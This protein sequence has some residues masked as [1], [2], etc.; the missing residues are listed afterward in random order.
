MNYRQVLTAAA[1]CTIAFG[2]AGA[3]QGDKKAPVTQQ[4]KPDSAKKDSKMAG[5]KSGAKKGSKKGAEKKD[6]TKAATKKP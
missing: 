6:S 2:V 1:L 4:A 5:K 3:Q